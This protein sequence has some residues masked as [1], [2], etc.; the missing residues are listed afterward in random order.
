MLVQKRMIELLEY[1]RPERGT[2]INRRLVYI[3]DQMTE[4]ESFRQITS[5]KGKRKIDVLSM[6]ENFLCKSPDGEA[7]YA[8]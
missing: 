8:Y 4:A 1:L 5:R 7:V 2:L 6:A 3:S